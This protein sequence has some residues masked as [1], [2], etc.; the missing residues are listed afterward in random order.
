MTRIG[1]IGLVLGVIALGI[2]AI[3]SSL[4]FADPNPSGKGQ[5]GLATTG[6]GI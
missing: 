3:G 2:A 4:S 1:K 5:T 6:L